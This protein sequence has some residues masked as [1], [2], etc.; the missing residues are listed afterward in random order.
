MQL[1]PFHEVYRILATHTGPAGGCGIGGGCGTGGAVYGNVV[2]FFGQL[3]VAV[4][5]LG[6]DG[7]HCVW[8]AKKRHQAWNCVCAVANRAARDYGRGWVLDGGAGGA[9]NLP[10]VHGGQ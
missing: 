4:C 7:G 8:V 10:A 2:P 5:V 1:I 3:V 9:G 6:R